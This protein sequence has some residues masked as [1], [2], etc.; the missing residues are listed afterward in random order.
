MEI[1]L[2]KFI[3]Y[4]FHPMF[5]PVYGLLLLF[6]MK[7]YFSFELALKARLILLSFVIVTTIIFPLLIVA[8]LKK[9]GFIKSYQ[10]VSREERRVPYLITAIFYFITYQMLR[11]MQLAEIYSFYFM[12][13]TFLLS[14]VVVINIWWKISI[15]MVGVGGVCGMLCGLA[16]AFSFD[17][18]FAISA[19]VLICGIVAYA[20]L[21][22]QTHKSSEVY[23][24]FL[25]GYVVLLG[26]YLLV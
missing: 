17:M 25:V 19:L 22:L 15:H 13:A 14:L 5:M 3:S 21:K 18:M 4:I 23:L 24:G 2:A 1:R 16:I 6:N 12:G 11:Q 9:Q 10:M 26:L 8:L 7:S 20:R